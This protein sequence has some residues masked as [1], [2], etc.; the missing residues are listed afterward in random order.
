MVTIVVGVVI[1]IFAA[2]LVSSRITTKTEVNVTTNQ[3]TQTPSPTT[4]SSPSI[5]RET[6]ASP[7]PTPKSTSAVVSSQAFQ[8]PNS[9]QVRSENNSTTYESSDDP[10]LITNWYKD[11]IKSLNMNAKS[12]VTTKTNGNILNKLV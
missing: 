3:Q 12:F 5:S 7:I 6:S 10:N 9:V 1:L 4:T 2:G 8:Y 11:K